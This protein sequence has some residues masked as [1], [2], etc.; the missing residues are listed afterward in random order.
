MECGELEVVVVDGYESGKEAGE[1]EEES[2]CPRRLTVGEDS[3]KSD[4]DGVNH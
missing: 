2:C 4:A 3:V 1:D